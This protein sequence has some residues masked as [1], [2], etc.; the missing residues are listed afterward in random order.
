MFTRILA[1]L[2]VLGVATVA[3]VS[4]G[5]VTSHRSTSG[6]AE[7]TSSVADLW[8]QPQLQEAPSLV[9]HWVETQRSSETITGE[10]GHSRVVEKV[11]QV[12]REKN[13]APE[14]SRLSA[15]MDLDRRDKG[16]FSFDLY[17]VGFDGSWLFRHD[18]SEARWVD[19]VFPLAVSDGIY[20]DFRFEVDGVDRAATLA[21][22]D[23]RVAARLFLEPRT[24]VRLHVSFRSRGLQSWAYRPTS[25]V[26][27][28]E[29]LELAVRTDFASID[30]PAG[31]MSP[32]SRVELDGGAA[33]TWKFS[34]ILTGS[35]MG[36]V[37]PGTI[38]PGELASELA[39]SAP[40]SLG[41]FLF[42]IG[43]LSVLRGLRI[44][45]MNQLLIAGAFFAFNLLFSYTADRLPVTVAFGLSS[46]VSVF[47][48]AS[49]LRLVVGPRFALLEAGLAQVLYQ[50]GFAA[51]H[52]WDGYTGL[53][54]TVLG[55]ATLF[56]VMQLTGRVKWDEVAFAP[57][58]SAV[59]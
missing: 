9:V 39:F 23:G 7:L 57:P 42:W 53:T 16:L 49:Y 6:R 2:F 58:R 48:V 26:G 25:G 13:L 34:R 22:V 41:L 4:L 46:V 19:V 45:L 20:D 32:T 14:Q 27:R 21:P 38:Q 11:V 30:F 51:A 5:G 55:V 33:L 1:S 35:S 54:I 8:G 18:D 56:L 50:V 28:V 44:H 10:D 59:G 15:D 37:V 29:D 12:A 3:W 24:D 17:A 40:V 47:L 52:F 31:S 36:V 43:M